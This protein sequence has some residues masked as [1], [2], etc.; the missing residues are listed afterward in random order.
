[1]SSGRSASRRQP[2]RRGRAGSFS[3]RRV[4]LSTARLGERPRSGP[5]G[6]ELLLWRA[7]AGRR[8]AHSGLG[9][10]SAIARP[11]NIYGPRQTAGLEGAVIAAFV[12]QAADGV[13]TI[14]GDGRQTRDFIHVRDVTDALWRLGQLDAAG[15]TWNVASGRRTSVRSLAET[16]ERTSGRPMQRT[17]GPR[18]EGDVMHSVL[19][20]RHMHTALGWRPVVPLAEG[21]QELLTAAGIF[22]L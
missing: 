3:R 4:A 10:P 18:R 21:I 20:S 17:Y 5:P 15:G 9:L 16:I 22:P 13:L 11:S 6:P 14:D 2:S 8:R 12:A 19:S 1:M 7:Q